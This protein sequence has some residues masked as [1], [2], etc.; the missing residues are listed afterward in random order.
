MLLTLVKISTRP[1][2]DFIYYDLCDVF[3]SVVL[4]PKLPYM[5]SL[6]YLFYTFCLLA[7]L[8]GFARGQTDPTWTV[9]V[10]YHGDS[11]VS[12]LIGREVFLAEQVGSAEGFNII[13]QTDFNNNPESPTYEN[14]FNYIPESAIV[15]THRYRLVATPGAE[16]VSSVPVETLPELNHDLPEVLQEFIEWSIE[17]YPADRYGL[18]MVDHGGAWY[19]GFGGDYQDGGEAVID[20]IYPQA[21]AETIRRA[22][23]NTGVGELA[24]FQFASC[25]MGNI[26]TM[27]PFIG[28]ADLY[29][30]AAEVTFEY[31]A[32]VPG[33]LGWLKDN[34]ATTMDAFGTEV[35]QLFRANRNPASSP[36][37]IIATYDMDELQDVVDAW[38][39][40]SVQATANYQPSWTSL[41]L[42][43]AQYEAYEYNLAAQPTLLADMGE[44]IELVVA[45]EA[46]PESVVAAGN[47]LLSELGDLIVSVSQGSFLDGASGLSFFY[48]LGGLEFTGLGSAY[49]NL[50]LT[51]QSGWG[52][53]LAEVSNQANAAVMP[54]FTIAGETTG[55]TAMTFAPLE[56]TL[57]ITAGAIYSLVGNVLVDLEDEDGTDTIILGTAFADFLPEASSVST[58]WS[59]RLPVLKLKSGTDTS[60]IGASIKG[61]NYD[62]FSS[63]ALVSDPDEPIDPDDDGLIEIFYRL[64]LDTLEFAIVGLQ[65]V[66]IGTGLTNS[67]DSSDIAG[68]ILTPLL[69][70]VGSENENPGSIADNFVYS[71]T[72]FQVPEDGM[73]SFEII[74]APLPDDFYEIEVSASDSFYRFAEP[75]NVMVKVNNGSYFG[76]WISEAETPAGWEY[77]FNYGWMYADFFPWVYVAEKS[78]W[79][80]AGST[81]EANN[82]QW[83]YSQST[84][85]LWTSVAVFPYFWS[86]DDSTWVLYADL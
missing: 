59:S 56:L 36:F 78:A 60:F 10:Y 43:T 47:V 52:S 15:G 9:M 6:R 40:F 67:L 69:P 17:N 81:G 12:A 54:A 65:T 2:H 11:D 18:I 27:Y 24:F 26:E 83:V 86:S 4:T 28:V 75:Q 41:R 3:K 29:I 13:A 46:S 21:T 82:A 71:V 30:G 44:F 50:P 84:G 19:G 48:P 62:L 85:W 49:E 16:V 66:D 70:I 5:K 20:G 72:S 80:Y 23:N 31:P 37:E 77:Q 64:D 76:G 68:A 58:G 53:Y 22:L 63:Y 42:L 33:S 55:L 61:K 51:L 1:K 7:A 34:R 73:D 32:N 57:D 79:L 14:N 8:C 35:A 74:F 38:N 25:L 39:T 45:D